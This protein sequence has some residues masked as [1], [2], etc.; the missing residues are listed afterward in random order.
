[1]E[2]SEAVT[3]SVTDSVCVAPVPVPVTVTVYV[4]VAV[5]APTA[6]VRVELPPAVIGFGLKD[7]V[8][9]GGMPLAPS[10]TLCAEPLVTAVEIVEAALPP[11]AAE[12]LPGLVLIEKSE[13]V[14]VSVTVMVCVAL[15]P[16]PVT[17]TE[18]VP[19]AVVAPAASVS[20]ELPPAVIELGLKEAVAPE[21]R[22]LAERATL[23]AE[24]L[25]TEV[26]IVDVVVPP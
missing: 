6:N 23:C 13:A 1:M 21:G 19:G 24:P 7:A 8:A 25:V 12:T 18:Y 3:V 9:P 22:P 4:P 15:A 10:V 2:K 26:E 17:V 20:V 11:C 14:T 16:V 5:L